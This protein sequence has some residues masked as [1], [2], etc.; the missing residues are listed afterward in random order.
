MIRPKAC[1]AFLL[2]KKSL[3]LMKNSSAEIDYE[4]G[5]CDNY[6]KS[7]LTTHG[8]IFDFRKDAFDPFKSDYKCI[9]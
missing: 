8:S 3:K 1:V 5:F 4:P 7:I 9:Q 2:W 6:Y